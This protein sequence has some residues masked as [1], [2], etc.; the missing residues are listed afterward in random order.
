MISK[1]MTIRLFLFQARKFHLL[2]IMN[3]IVPM[4]DLKLLILNLNKW[5]SLQLSSSGHCRAKCIFTKNSRKE[6]WVSP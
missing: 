6:Y 2:E 3:L 1:E 4:I 5:M